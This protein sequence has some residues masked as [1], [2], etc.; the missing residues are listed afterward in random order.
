[1]HLGIFSYN[2]GEERGTWPTP[3]CRSVEHDPI[4]LATTVAT[5][6]C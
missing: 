3:S 5:A 2:V 6:T 4:V 1:M